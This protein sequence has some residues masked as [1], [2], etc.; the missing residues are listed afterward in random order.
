VVARSDCTQRGRAWAIGHEENTQAERLAE[1]QIESTPA[2]HGMVAGFES[3]DTVVGQPRGAAPYY[4]IAMPQL[5][6]SDWIISSEAAEQELSGQPQ[7]DRDD[8]KGEIGFVLVLVQAQLGAGR[9]AVDEACVGR[10][11]SEA[12]DPS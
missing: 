5:H 10:K 8:R 6:A 1:S 12:C 9:V 2:G 3:I 7:R 4:D 11:F